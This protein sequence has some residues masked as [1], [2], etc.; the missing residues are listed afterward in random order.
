LNTTDLT[1]VPV[2]QNLENITT[3]GNITVDLNTSDIFIVEEPNS[4]QDTLGRAGNTS[5][6]NTTDS[7]TAIVMV[8]SPGVFPVQDTTVVRVPLVLVAD[9][10]LSTGRRLQTAVNPVI[11]AVSGRRHF[12]VDSTSLTVD[13]L[14]FQGAP[15]PAYSGGLE[16]VGTNP[17]GQFVR[18][19]FRS[20]RWASNGGGVLLGGSAAQCS[21]ET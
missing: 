12:V 4:F 16:F 5:N 14:I 13:G 11:V 18:T 6:L 21:I 1:C 15:A 10:G 2:P 3:Q 19:T 8:I 7:S 9:S 20:C 17:V